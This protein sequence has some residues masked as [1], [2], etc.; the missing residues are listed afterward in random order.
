VKKLNKDKHMRYK[1]EEE[2]RKRLEERLIEISTKMFEN[3][4]PISIQNRKVASIL[5]LQ[6]R[7]VSPISIT[8]HENKKVN[9]NRNKKDNIANYKLD[10]INL[11]PLSSKQKNSSI[12]TIK[13]NSN[14]NTNQSNNLN[15]LNNINN[16]VNKSKSD[17]NDTSLRSIK[18]SPYYFNDP[19]LS[20]LMDLKNEFK[21]K[22]GYHL[23]TTNLMEGGDYSTHINI[24]FDGNL[25]KS[26]D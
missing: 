3:M 12:L 14:I 11:P 20:R 13:D 26:P 18:K 17:I 19:K 6:K 5:K 21:Y 7:E 16:S 4:P 1:R 23:D 10:E 2:R 8:K 22:Y 9:S 24:I 25:E 15:S